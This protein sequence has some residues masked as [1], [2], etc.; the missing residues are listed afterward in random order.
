MNFNNGKKEISNEKFLHNTN[1]KVIL[2]TMYIR[3]RIIF[4]NTNYKLK[5]IYFEFGEPWWLFSTRKRYRVRFS[6]FNKLD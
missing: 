4:I 6:F 1:F 2:L 5:E 3:L